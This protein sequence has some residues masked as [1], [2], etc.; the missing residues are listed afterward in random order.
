MAK[1]SSRQFLFLLFNFLFLC[2]GLGLVGFVAWTLATIPT[3]NEFI[4]GT[5]YVGFMLTLLFL[6]LGLIFFI[7]AEKSQIP[8]VMLDSWDG[9]NT[10]TQYKI[11]SELECCGIQNYTEYGTDVES[12]PSSC[13]VVYG[14]TGIIEK[15]VDNLFTVDCLTQMQTWLNDHVPIWVSVIVAVAVIECLSGL[16]SCIFLQRVQKKLKVEPVNDDDGTN[17]DIEMAVMEA[18]SSDDRVSDEE[19][20]ENDNRINSTG[21]ILVTPASEQDIKDNTTID[22]LSEK[23]VD[24]LSTNS[25][26]EVK[27]ETEDVIHSQATIDDPSL[28]LVASVSN[29]EPAIH[30]TNDSIA[31]NEVEI[32]ALT[33]TAP[34]DGQDNR[35][36]ENNDDLSSNQNTP[37]PSVIVVASITKGE[38]SV[39]RKTTDSSD[40]DKVD[41][42]VHGERDEDGDL[43]VDNKDSD[44]ISQ[45]S[46]PDRSLIVVVSVTKGETSTD[47][48][49]NKIVDNDQRDIETLTRTPPLDDTK[50][51]KDEKVEDKS[52]CD[53]TIVIIASE[54]DDENS[55]RSENKAIDESIDEKSN[56][57]KNDTMSIHSLPDPTLLLVA[58][59][60]R[61][62]TTVTDTKDDAN[63][64]EVDT[65][66]MVQMTPKDTNKV[67]RQDNISNPEPSDQNVLLVASLTKRETA[68]K[69][70]FEDTV[71]TMSE[72]QPELKVK[73]IIKESN[74]DLSSNPIEP[75]ASFITVTSLSH[76]ENSDVKEVTDSADKVEVGSVAQTQMNTVAVND[77]G[78]TDITQDINSEHIVP[79]KSLVLFTSEQEIEIS[80]KKETTD[81][82]KDYAVDTAVLEEMNGNREKENNDEKDDV[83]ISI[84]STSEPSLLFVASLSKDSS[85]IVDDKEMETTASTHMVSED[86]TSNIKDENDDN[87][88][89]NERTSDLSVIAVA[90]VT[91]GETCGIK[92]VTDSSVLDQVGS[93]P[94]EI[95]E[96]GDLKDDHKDG[97]SISRQSE[98]DLSLVM[99]VPV[100]KGDTVEEGKIIVDN[101]QG[102]IAT[103]TWTTPGDETKDEKN[104]DTISNKSTSDQDMESIVPISTTTKT[105]YSEENDVNTITSASKAIDASMEEINDENKDDTISIHS[106]PDPTVLLVASVS[107]TAVV[108]T[109]DT[110]DNIEMNNIQM[111]SSDMKEINTEEKQADVSSPEPPDPSLILVPSVTKEETLPENETVTVSEEQTGLQEMTKES[112]DERDEE[113]N[114]NQ[115]KPDVPLLM[116][117]SVSHAEKSNV[118]EATDSVDNYEVDSVAQIQMNAVDISEDDNTDMIKDINSDHIVTDP[119]LKMLISEKEGEMST[120]KEI[121]DSFK[122]EVVDTVALKQIEHNTTTEN[123]GEKDDDATISIQ[124]TSE[125]S[126]FLV[127]SLSNEESF[128][129]PA[130]R[131][132]KDDNEGEI[133]ALKRIY[134][135]NVMDNENDVTG[136]DTSSNH[137]T[138]DPSVEAETCEITKATDSSKHEKVE[139]FIPEEIEEN[140]DLKD[141]NKEGDNI[142]HQSTPDQSLVMV[143]SVTKESSTDK[144]VN[145]IV[146]ND[147]GDIETPTSTT[148]DDVKKDEKDDDTVSNQST[149]CEEMVLITPT[150]TKQTP[151]ENKIMDYTSQDDVNTV[152]SEDKDM[153][154]LV[155][156][157]NCENKED[158]ISIHSLPDPTLLLVTTESRTE[159][160]VMENKDAVDDIEDDTVALEQMTP[161]DVK[162]ISK[163]NSLDNI[164]SHNPFD[165]SLMFVATVT[166]E[167]TLPEKEI[168]FKDAPVREDVEGM[169]IKEMIKYN[170]DEHENDTSSTPLEPDVSSIR[171]A[172]V[173]YAERTDVNELTDAVDKF[174][175]SSEAQTQMK[176]ADVKDD[177]KPDITEDIR[178][179][180]MMPN[181]HLIMPKS[182]QEGEKSGEMET[183]DLLKDEEVDR[184]ALEEMEHNQAMENND[185]KDYDVTISV[186]ST[187]EPSSLLGATFSNAETFI[188]EGI[189]DV[190]GDDEGETGALNQTVPVDG[191]DEN[192]NKIIGEPI[193]LTPEMPLIVA[194]S[195]SNEETSPI[196]ETSDRG[197]QDNGAILKVSREESKDKKDIGSISLH[198]SHDKSDSLV[199]YKV[200]T[201]SFEQMVPPDV[202]SAMVGIT[203]SKE[204][205]AN[206]AVER[207]AINDVP[208]NDSNSMNIT[209]DPSL[210]LS[211]TA[212]TAELSAQANMDAF[213][214]DQPDD[215]KEDTTNQTEDNTVSKQGTSDS[216]LQLVASMS[217]LDETSDQNGMNTITLDQTAIDVPTDISI[218]SPPDKASTLEARVSFSKKNAIKESE[219]FSGIEDM[220]TESSDVADGAKFKIADATTSNDNTLTPSLTVV[221]PVPT[222]DAY[223][224]EEKSENGD[225]VDMDILPMDQIEACGTDETV[226]GLFSIQSTHDSPSTDA[227]GT[228]S[229]HVGHARYLS[230]VEDVGIEALEQDKHKNVKDNYKDEFEDDSTPNHGARDPSLEPVAMVSANEMHATNE[231]VDASQTEITETIPNTSEEEDIDAMPKDQTEDCDESDSRKEQIDEDT[232][233]NLDIHVMPMEI[234]PLVLT[235][236]SQKVVTDAI[237]L[238]HTEPSNLKF[239]NIIET[240]NDSISKQITLDLTSDLVAPLPMPELTSIKE[241]DNSETENTDALPMHEKEPCYLENDSKDVKDDDNIINQTLKQ[242]ELLSNGEKSIVTENKNTT[243]NEVSDT[244]KLEQTKSDDVTRDSKEEITDDTEDTL[245]SSLEL[246]ALVSTNETYAVNADESKIEVID[247]VPINQTIHGDMDNETTTNP[248]SEM[249]ASVLI[250]EKSFIEE[251][252]SSEKGIIGACQMDQTEAC[253]V[254]NNNKNEAEDTNSTIQSTQ[255]SS[256][257]QAPLVSPDEKFT[258]AECT[259]STANENPDTPEFEKT[260]TDVVMDVSEERVSKDTLSNHGMNDPSL[261]L[262]AM[263]STEASKQFSGATPTEQTAPGGLKNNDYIETTNDPIFNQITLDSTLNLVVPVSMPE[264]TSI[265]ETDNSDTEGTK[266]LPM[267]EKEPCNLN[268]DIK[269][270]TD[271]DTFTIQTLKH[272]DLISTGENTTEKKVLDT[273][274][275]EQMKA[276]DVTSKKEEMANDTPSNEDTR[277]PTLELG[278]IVLAN[279]NSVLN[280]V[281]GV[282]RMELVDAVTIE[283]TL[284]GDP[285]FEMDNEIT[286]IP[287]SGLI[288]TVSI[289]AI[290]SIEV[291]DSSEKDVIVACQMDETEACVVENDNGNEQEDTFTSQN[292]SLKQAVQVSTDEKTTIFSSELVAPVLTPHMVSI[293]ETDSSEKEGMETLPM[294]QTDDTFTTQTLKLTDEKY[295]IT[296]DTATTELEQR[297][298]SDVTNDN[299][300]ESTDG[301]LCKEG[302]PYP[303]IKPVALVSTNDMI[304]IDEVAD[305]S[306]GE[307]VDTIPILDDLVSTQ[308]T[309]AVVEQ[310]DT[311]GDEVPDTTALEKGEGG[312]VTDSKEVIADSS[313]SDHGTHDP[314]LGM[315]ALLSTDKS[316][317]E[318]AGAILT[319]HTASV[320]LQ[321]NT[322]NKTTNDTVPDQIPLDLNSELVLT[323]PSSESSEMPTIKETESME[324]LPTDEM[325]SCHFENNNKDVTSDDI[326]T[327]Q[328]IQDP[329]FKRTNE[330]SVM[331]EN[332]NIT[333]IEISDTQALGQTETRHVTTDNEEIAEAT[334]SNERLHDPSLEI[335]ALVSTDQTYATDAIADKSEKEVVEQTVPAL[336]T[337]DIGNETAPDPDSKLI[338]SVSI[339]VMSTVEEPDLSAK[340]SIG[341]LQID[342]TVACGVENDDKGKN[343]DITFTQIT[344]DSSLKQAALVSTDEKFTIAEQTD[345][346]ENEDPDTTEPEQMEADIVTGEN[347]KE[348]TEDTISSH[349]LH[350]PSL[351]L[352]V[353][354]STKEIDEIADASKEEAFS[355]IPIEQTVTSDLTIDIQTQ[356]SSSKLAAS[357][358]ANTSKL[359]EQ[360]DIT[361]N[362]H[363]VK[364]AL[365]KKTDNEDATDG[366]K[367]EIA[368]YSFANED[369]DQTVPDD[370]TLD[371]GNETAPDSHS[372]LI[373]SVSTQD[374]SSVGETD[375]S[376]KESFDALQIDQMEVCEVESK[377]ASDTITIQNTKD[378]SSKQAAL[379][380]TNKTSSIVENSDTSYN[381]DLETAALGK[382]DAT[383][384]NKE[385]IAKITMSDHNRHDPSL[386]SNVMA[387]ND[388]TS[389]INEDPDTAK[390]VEADT[391]P[392]YK[393]AP[394]DLESSLEMS[395]IKESN[396][397]EKE[398]KDT[399]PM[400]QV[401]SCY[402]RNDKKEETANDCIN[403]QNTADSSLKADALESADEIY[404]DITNEAS[405][406]AA[407][408]QNEAGD[409]TDGGTEKLADETVQ[410]DG[411]PEPSGEPNAVVSNN[412]R[413][414]INVDID[415]S[416]NGHVDITTSAEHDMNVFPMDQMEAGATKH[417]SK[418]DLAEETI[419]AHDTHNSS[420]KPADLESNDGES[421]NEGTIDS[422][423]KEDVDSEVLDDKEDSDVMNYSKEEAAE[424]V[425]LSLTTD[426]TPEEGTNSEAMEMNNA[427]PILPLVQDTDEKLKPKGDEIISELLN[428]MEQPIKSPTNT[429]TSMEGKHTEGVIGKAET[430][431]VKDEFALEQPNNQESV[432]LLY[433]QECLEAGRSPLPE[434]S[435]SQIEE[436]SFRNTDEKKN[437]RKEVQDKHDKGTVDEGKKIESKEEQFMHLEGEENKST[438]DEPVDKSHDQIQDEVKQ[439]EKCDDTYKP[440]KLEDKNECQAIRD[441]DQTNAEEDRTTNNVSKPTDKQ[442]SKPSVD[443]NE[444]E[445]QK[446]SEK[447]SLDIHPKNIT[448]NQIASDSEEANGAELLDDH[449]KDKTPKNGDIDGT[450]SSSSLK[451]DLNEAGC[452]RNESEKDNNSDNEEYKDALDYVPEV[453]EFTLA[454]EEKRVS[455]KPKVNPK[456]K[457]QQRI[458]I[459]HG[460]GKSSFKKGAK[461]EVKETA[462]KGSKKSTTEAEGK[463]PKSI[464]KEKQNSFKQKAAFVNRVVWR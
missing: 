254:E 218:H 437:G 66:A 90:T 294:D 321:H 200:D 108:D 344:R 57:D 86:V 307:I 459:S 215:V 81:S 110:I 53:Q 1:C 94:E 16:A 50:D 439:I 230:V 170:K 425:S 281:T 462:T 266:T 378:S 143:V 311:T 153:A 291:T 421:T 75:D 205:D 6:E 124:S 149:C 302:K 54:R 375:S 404:T 210:T 204:K 248:T 141:D 163:E 246:G 152:T 331:E 427:G 72:E 330:T 191:K 56:E 396:T 111:A 221:H 399:L 444:D 85:E 334:I 36:D 60:S 241:S 176:T 147:Q 51:A 232:N 410:N 298:A 356:D 137:S 67:D 224:V 138:S 449:I 285:K 240:T 181:P 415:A 278:E 158:T 28:I 342:Q 454:P 463:G 62:E 175:V 182:E 276:D 39:T 238:E 80:G 37:E 464:V 184:A 102:D 112:K 93:V 227:D 84:H 161:L 390:K 365:E 414:A 347:K 174:E 23:N 395:T 115:I 394:S 286:P 33:Q 234:I 422:S 118:K 368:R 49:A 133:V 17:A 364:T 180:H 113:T 151:S 447:T 199:P 301:T 335:V 403:I 363:L 183:T 229:D 324:T 121:S 306:V 14:V 139:S 89:S 340:E 148:P 92:K 155:E 21:L 296:K 173:S 3:A 310:S 42:S 412:E 373:A 317:K 29:K 79:E 233:S 376:E 166:Q 40:Q 44:N 167:E 255:D 339:Q 237:P 251:T 87:L 372:E 201:A 96:H 451:I 70:G 260:D 105:N 346:T 187:F 19:N 361:N 374:I 319:E 432:D 453:E 203:N 354:V 91:N 73:E 145:T 177:K 222:E 208:T 52:T 270:E 277:D 43:K 279:E 393:T 242:T 26:S 389:S 83:T 380:S 154:V 359:V 336:L 371:I 78:N 131:D 130:N 401:D 353:L 303:S 391:L 65:V 144:E 135:N 461:K 322:D 429:M 214:L 345:V 249:I 263:V 438:I 332:E 129:Y 257:K 38:T 193:S 61:K 190:V 407:L 434:S 25:Q 416:E 341:E 369:F 402:V 132:A 440:V 59:V 228:N 328:S 431:S 433:R 327:T 316:E 426:Q 99:A 377:R 165:P 367:E 97:D 318:V 146:D 362:D 325:V 114:S 351:E 264:I 443:Q 213:A 69:N 268:N 315:S 20:Q 125:P 441:S 379:V 196:K 280:E 455:D 2:L 450:I 247:A 127:A 269:D 267:D 185:K 71:G 198:V 179:E 312:N 109:K 4:S 314:C 178:S 348:M 283:Q 172:A 231:D 150:S 217:S 197:A 46:E 195:L 423:E 103:P 122:E 55:V 48:E 300:E 220:S 357:V 265:K 32:V 385:E 305:T 256:L 171:V 435:S 245:G 134:P 162:D 273:T 244:I 297:E 186:Q 456:S 417:V 261:E 430:R 400:D 22:Y 337:L 436:M 271:Y 272:S 68:Q 74:D 235:N 250:Q 206:V 299:K 223:N 355:A 9:L 58:S 349:G 219:D 289:P 128:S 18:G 212:N 209:F 366:N 76:A 420:P 45:H 41:S 13:F 428:T 24:S 202:T 308:D 123:N 188:E 11:Q 63:G 236:V 156:E 388:E 168:F 398:A 169:D 293:K 189:T 117:A 119:S 192:K 226:D 370:L 259:N 284:P 35:A 136:D 159:T 360:S 116:A 107:K 383:D 323:V 243:V 452:Q 382:T 424:D 225:V 104:D 295:I 457:G 12:Y 157:R 445:I 7:Y 309:F 446:D 381:E 258:V 384:D 15:T 101:Y 352:D 413:L 326:L 406:T 10:D 140:G 160:S 239:N 386:E 164:S 88:S 408:E 411:K 252:E 313:I 392:I 207:T 304:S 292:L 350:D 98:P 274:I 418:D 77:D 419:S 460:K 387:S 47:K 275:L 458:D 409:L 8:S 288:A 448:S 329:S 338:A 126:L 358:S 95:E 106:L 142:S 282:S 30:E 253:E 64:I 31:D 262:D 290:T 343:E 27:D 5:H 100:T 397:S 333:K 405:N 287:T 442:I 320:D 211:A 194:A 82:L 120:E 34:G 216:C